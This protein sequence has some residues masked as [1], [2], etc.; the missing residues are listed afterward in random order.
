MP[1]PLAAITAVQELQRTAAQDPSTTVRLVAGPGTGKSSA[2]E[3]R[4]Y[5][6]LAQGVAPARIFVISFT[7]ASAKDLRERI[8][9]YCET[10]GQSGGGAVQV[11]TL[12]SL[13][14]RTLRRA[15]LLGRY[16]VD[17][18]VLDDWEVANIFDPEFGAS[19][20]IGSKKRR[21]QIR[22][23]HEAFWSTGVNSPPN[24]LPPKP[25]IS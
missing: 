25:P 12:H 4:V 21:A 11:S 17:P 8:K 1:I 20:G 23:F 16:P 10:R 5:W 2:I 13:A 24:Y 6:L 19:S 14:L 7:R 22:Y 18:L 9:R 15:G 3:Q